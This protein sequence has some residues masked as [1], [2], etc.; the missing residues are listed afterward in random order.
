MEDSNILVDCRGGMMK[1]SS[2]LNSLDP[3]AFAEVDKARKKAED[4]YSGEI[5]DFGVGDPTEPTPKKAVAEGVKNAVMNPDEG[6]PSYEGELGFRESVSKWFKE[7]F[8]VKM[9]PESEITATLGSKQAVF[10]LPMAYV[11]PGDSVLVPDP[12]Y[13]PYTTG[14]KQRGAQIN[15]MPL[16]EEND[17]LPDLDEISSEAAEESKIMWIN[18]PNNPTSKVAPKSFLKEAID[19]CQDNDIILASDEAYS[20]MYYENERKPVSLF[21][22]DGGLDVGLVFHS[23]SKRSNMTNYRIGFVTGREENLN[24]FKKVQ[25]NFHSGQSQVLQSAAVGALSEENHVEK[26]RSL[27]EEKREVLVPALDKTGFEEIY[28]EGTF[29]VW[30]KVPEDSSS[31][32]AVK[33]LLNE[34]GLNTTP[35]SALAKTQNVADKFLRLALVPSVEEIE[36]AAERLEKEKVFA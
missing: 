22:L 4:E 15:F 31:V 2:Y 27:Y 35:G 17:F 34:K 20:E 1:V 18:Y 12:G 28:S 14:A 8:D 16:K 25:T 5:L 23:L 10:C 33:L 30:A 24:P 32:E 3:Y 21:N 9:D 7:R 29:Y 19:F 26:M 13:P 11:N 36:E 6:Y